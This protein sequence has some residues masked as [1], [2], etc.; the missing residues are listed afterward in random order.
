ML[1]KDK[2]FFLMVREPALLMVGCFL[3]CPGVGILLP[4]VLYFGKFGRFAG[5]L[6]SSLFVGLLLEVSLSGDS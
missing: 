6:L 4:D 5:S 1:R 2:Y 3:V